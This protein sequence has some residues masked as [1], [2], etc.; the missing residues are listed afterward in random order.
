MHEAARDLESPPH[1]AGVSHHLRVSA[2]PKPNHL[3]DLAHARIDEIALH[4]V[5]LRMH[6]EVLCA[7]QVAV[8]RRVLKDQAAVAANI[9]AL[10]HDVVTGDVRS[11]AGWLDERAKHAARR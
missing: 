7:G 8:E 2:V 3:E 5:E 9:V 6:L 4:A 1:A 11:P 10:R